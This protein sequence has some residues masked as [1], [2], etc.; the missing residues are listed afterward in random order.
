MTTTITLYRIRASATRDGQT[1]D[2]SQ[3]EVLGETY[4]VTYTA[5]DAADAALEDLDES[6]AEYQLDPSTT[7]S[8]SEIPVLIGEISTEYEDG[9]ITVSARVEMP[10]YAGPT[11]W[12]AK[13]RNTAAGVD[14]LEPAGDSIDAW[15]DDTLA[16][17]L[18]ANALLVVGLE[19]LALA[20]MP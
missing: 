9:A 18:P 14:G 11:C 20:G 10:G 12:S 13:P 8:I 2:C 5:R 6:I 1:I 17:Y 7:Y 15:A 16:M 4:G 19:I 3:A